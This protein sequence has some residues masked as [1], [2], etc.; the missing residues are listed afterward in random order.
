[1]K[2]VFDAVWQ[3]LESTVIYL[4]SVH[5]TVSIRLKFR[6]EASDSPLPLKRGNIFGTFWHRKGALTSLVSLG[7]VLRHWRLKQKQQDTALYA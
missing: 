5:I 3:T 7:L 1:V 6:T 4:V 2:N